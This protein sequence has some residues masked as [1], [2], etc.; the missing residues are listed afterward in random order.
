MKISDALAG[1]EEHLFR[2]CSRDLFSGASC[3]IP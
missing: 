3:Q 2:Y 1:G